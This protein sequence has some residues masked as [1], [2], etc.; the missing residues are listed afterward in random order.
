[1]ATTEYTVWG[2]LAFELLQG[3]RFFNL[4][5]Q[6]Q[7][8]TLAVFRMELP[9]IVAIGLAIAALRYTD[10]DD[11][12]QDQK[13]R[14][15]SI[16]IAVYG[17]VALLSSMYMKSILTHGALILLLAGWLWYTRSQVE[18]FNNFN[19]IEPST[20][21]HGDMTLNYILN[22]PLGLEIPYHV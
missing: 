21:Y 14:E 20:D 5:P 17:C 11:N 18:S 22:T 4:T 1:M 2:L 10:T 13:L 15:M 7:G 9:R 6:L 3:Y 16:I 8:S 12:T 19:E